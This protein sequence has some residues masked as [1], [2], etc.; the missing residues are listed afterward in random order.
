[1][2]NFTQNLFVANFGSG[3]L[4]LDG[5]YGSGLYKIWSITSNNG[6]GTWPNAGDGFSE[7]QKNPAALAIGKSLNNGKSIVFKFSM[8]DLKNLTVSYA[9]LVS[10]NGFNTQTW[11]YSTDG[12]SWVDCGSTTIDERNVFKLVKVTAI[13]TLDNAME[14]FF[15][16]TLNGATTD[17]GTSQV[18]FD[19]IKFK[20]SPVK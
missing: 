12:K 13:S 8:K 17:D 18:R 20:A 15:K 1:M 14:A 9:T 7:E 3:T 4:Y 16:I 6:V 2:T 19:N 11:A 10:P 5:T